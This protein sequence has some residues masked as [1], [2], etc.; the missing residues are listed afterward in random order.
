MFD[1]SF[2]EW[3]IFCTFA[4]RSTI[5]SNNQ[6]T[7]VD[8]MANQSNKSIVY[9]I[10]LIRKERDLFNDPVASNNWDKVKKA[11][12]EDFEKDNYLIFA[13]PKNSTIIYERHYMRIPIN[14]NAVLTVGRFDG[15]NDYAT[16]R[17]TIESIG[18]FEPY[19]VF[20][21]FSHAF[22]KPDTLANMVKQAFNWVLE[23]YNLEVKLELCEGVEDI[24]KWLDDNWRS[25]KKEIRRCP[26]KSMARHGFEEAY[27]LIK[28]KKAKETNKPKKVNIKSDN[29]M[30]Y[31]VKGDKVR[32]V[33]VLHELIDGLT[34]AKDIARPIRF[35][36]DHQVF[37]DKDE[38]R[39]P[40]KAFIKEFPHLEAHISESAYNIKISSY[41][42]PYRNSLKYKNLEKIFNM[43][44]ES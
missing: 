34:T 38:F 7:T 19:V 11:L 26:E 33:K 24:S 30:D 6:T 16:V 12:E 3:G 18:G 4:A 10:R 35:L 39:L 37:K 17:I 15:D 27:P 44:L 1:F 5:I 40:Y 21:D 23:A 43:V 25:F 36:C 9:K 32:I 22:S 42:Q 20:E 41:K 31:I 8:N 28:Q 14:G 29:I 2:V 13:H